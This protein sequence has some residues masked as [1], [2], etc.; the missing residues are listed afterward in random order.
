VLQLRG[1][2]GRD[3]L[4]SR[5][6]GYVLSVEPGELDLEVFEQL[7]REGR[8][9]GKPENLR[10]A[11]A[12]WRGP[13]LAEFRD[14][15]FAEREIP[16][17]AEL[18]LE[19]L[20]ERIEAELAKGDGGELVGE[21]EALSAEHPLRERFR[22]QLMLAL[23]RSGRQAEAL[24]VYRDTRQLLTEQLGLEPSPQLREIE[25]AILTHDPS[26]RPREI[27]RP[28][29]WRPRRRH[30]WLVGAALVASAVAAAVAIPLLPSDSSADTVLP[31]SVAVIDPATGRL[32]ANFPVGIGPTA[33]VV[34]GDSI[35]V[36]NRADR[37][38][39]RVDPARRRITQ[40]I[41]IGT[42]VRDV[43]VGDGVLWVAGGYDGTISKLDLVTG[44]VQETMPVGSE[45]ATAI[46]VGPDSV[47]VTSGATTVLHIDPST[48]HVRARVRIVA[49]PTGIAADQR[50]HVWV[51]GLERGVT[52]ILA[53]TERVYDVNPTPGPVFAPIVGPDGRLLAIVG[54]GDS[55]I[56]RFG[57]TSFD[58]NTAAGDTSWPSPGAIDLALDR[59]GV[60]V[61]HRDGTISLLDN[62]TGGT[63]KKIKLGG[64]P[65]AIAAGAG[66][67]WVTVGAA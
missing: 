58:D 30:A 39:S 57:V 6:G 47:W 21:L 40:T 25:L 64:R 42:D 13:P 3:R 4:L 2:L 54:A 10:T 26:L 60:W 22:R 8:A 63:L 14:D 43:A 55:G 62:I 59:R 65:T 16:R 20:E 49:G 37:T 36:A 53:S 33:V 61:A 46:A 44:A 45:S 66:S 19:A 17:L 1:T 34:G 38:V 28:L 51:T 32:V 23:Y 24:E 67:V 35:W 52:F 41:G 7:L 50:G 27:H 5:G 48:E 31:N 11:L 9:S 18:R 29:A 15:P 12:L 56:R